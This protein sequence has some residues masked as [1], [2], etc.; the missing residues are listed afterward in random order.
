MKNT[1][2][3]TTIM[4]S[5]VLAL[6]LSF[7]INIYAA[8]IYVHDPMA[9][10]KAAKDIIEDPKAV[11]GYS[12]S[13]E[14]DRL[15][16]FARLDWTDK[17]KV[18][19]RRAQREAYHESM[20]ELYDMIKTM[21]AE[22]KDIETIA[23]AVSTRRNEIRLEAYK[24]DPEGLA[25]A[26]KSNLEKYGDEKG[27]SPDFFFKKYGSWETVLEKALS[28]NPGAD[29]LLG[30]YDKYYDTYV[31]PASTAD[32]KSSQ[33]GKGTSG[34][35]TYTVVNGDSLWKIAVNR[36]GDGTLWNKIYELNKGIIKNP[37][38]IYTGQVLQLQ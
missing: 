21:K 4:L 13:P 25:V 27:G 6:L 1:V 14:S 30:L 10:P 28:A 36:L 22:G 24:D 12:P 3:K 31:I 32:S 11:Y 8:G 38:L 16:E 17:A 35:G 9:N 7:P 26:K 2:K 37:D 33:T 5:A 19:E 15:K 20:K 23:R 34:S 29:A 18:E